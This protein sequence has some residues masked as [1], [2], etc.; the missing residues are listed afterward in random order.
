[1]APV[2]QQILSD[3]SVMTYSKGIPRKFITKYGK[4]D[5]HY[6]EFG[7]TSHGIRNNILRMI[8]E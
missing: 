3:R 7:L 4:T 8:S 2:V 6:E 5:E 1:M